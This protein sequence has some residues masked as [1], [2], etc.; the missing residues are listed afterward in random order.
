MIS[1]SWALWGFFLFEWFDWSLSHFRAHFSLTLREK[2]RHGSRTK[3]SQCCQ[4]DVFQ[5]VSLKKRGIIPNCD[6]WLCVAWKSWITMPGSAWASPSDDSPI[7][8]MPASLTHSKFDSLVRSCVAANV[9]SL[10]WYQTIP[11]SSEIDLIS[12]QHPSG[13]DGGDI[14]IWSEEIIGV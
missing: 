12:I 10:F 14:E 11:S 4:A 6:L 1:F 13:A 3:P 7:S 9:T 2:K 5:S 8:T